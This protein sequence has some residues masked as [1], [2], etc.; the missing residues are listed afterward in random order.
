MSGE[1]G[2][3]GNDQ[4]PLNWGPPT[5]IFTSGIASLT[6]ATA[7]SNHNQTSALSSSTNWYRSPHAVT[8]GG[9]FKR[10]QFNSISQQ[11]PRGTFYAARGACE[12]SDFQDFL[13][14]IP[15]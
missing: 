2:I 13:L 6:D 15:M 14:G 10:Q 7:A 12:I 4:S 9:D 3:S 11:N 8:F 5:L 1:A